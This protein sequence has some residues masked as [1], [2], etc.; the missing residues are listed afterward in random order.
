MQWA[1]K[2]ELI[3]G[4]TENTLV[5]QGYA[6]RAQ[7]AAILYRF[8]TTMAGVTETYT[9]T[10]DYN[11][12]DAEAD[13]TVSVKDGDTVSAPEAPSRSGYTFD[14]WFTKAEGGSKFDFKTAV[15]GD[16]TLYAHWSAQSTGGGGGG[17]STPAPDPSVATVTNET[18]LKNALADVSKTTI[19]LGADIALTNTL[20]VSRNVTINGSG[21]TLSV[22]DGQ[23]YI[24]SMSNGAKV[25][26]VIFQTPGAAR[27]NGAILITGEDVTVN[28]CTFNRDSTQNEAIAITST[29]YG[30]TD[31]QITNITITNNKIND[32]KYGMYFNSL[33]N[34]T[35]T[36]NTITNT[37]YNG[38]NIAADK[39]GEENKA[40]NITVTGNTMTGIS[41]ANYND[42]LYS[43]GISIGTNS[44]NK[45]IVVK[46]NNIT[47]L[48]DKQPVYF[49]AAS[50]DLKAA[51][52]DPAVTKIDLT[53]M[54][55]GAED[56]YDVY[57]VDHAVTITGG[58]VYG[59]FVVNT[60]DVAFKGVTINN[61]ITANDNGAA[62]NGINA[63][64]DN[65]TVTGC[66]FTAKT[67]E[68]QGESNGIVIFPKTAAGSY[69][70]TDNTFN[71]YKVS[72]RNNMYCSAGIFVAEGFPMDKK[73]FFT[74]VTGNSAA[75][76][77]KPD[78]AMADNTFTDCAYGYVRQD[79]FGW[80]EIAV[81]Q[82]TR[83]AIVCNADALENAVKYAGQNA[84]VKMADD[85]ALSNTLE[86]TQTITIDGNG[87]TLSASA[88]ETAMNGNL[89][90]VGSVAGCTLTLNNVTAD[91]SAAGVDSSNANVAVRVTPQDHLLGN[92][93]AANVNFI[94]KVSNTATAGDAFA[95]QVGASNAPT[96]TKIT[97]T[98]CTADCKGAKNG[99]LTAN[100]RG[101]ILGMNSPVTADSS[102][103]GC[104]KKN[105][106][107]F[108][109]FTVNGIAN[110]G[111]T[112][113]YMTD[114]QNGMH[115]RD[116]GE[117]NK[118]YNGS[119][120]VA[121]TGTAPTAE[122]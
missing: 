113:P 81:G 25:D 70:I 122:E 42:P 88:G 78:T 20:D 34:A 74:D 39:E 51:L 89:I 35:I 87:K 53:G 4:V 8:C 37:R 100:E 102:I 68:E 21:H 110:I 115:W 72:I 47:M 11:Y 94:A 82:T 67:A 32:M 17:G 49:A 71:G 30:H 3:N 116:Q 107:M 29:Y 24:L 1:N 6:T 73:P 64:T 2:A 98:D 118:E 44:D 58:T 19:K 27:D 85:I 76:T 31:Q 26:N 45:T 46:E 9:V 61:K 40:S 114:L 95:I 55:V 5:P 84:V 60:D 12:K 38:I 104:S 66:T 91:A 62:K 92:L 18:E 13:K 65:L 96:A 16:L 99:D 63:Y 108:D 111:S 59:S 103:T 23:Q 77:T 28:N 120:W 48:N 86:V 75:L 36:G 50:A 56:R 57:N 119:A 83:Y 97:L 33:N 22:A 101:Y 54:T 43:S 90:C 69:T 112:K 79:G 106:G 41:S 80:D 109:F 10:F 121:I 15:T 117:S 7:V 14:G 105:D 93:A 52:A